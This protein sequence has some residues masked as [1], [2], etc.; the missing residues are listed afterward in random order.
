MN[1]NHIADLA[2]NAGITLSDDG[3]VIYIRHNYSFS[4]RSNWGVLWFLFGGLFFIM[5]PFIKHSGILSTYIGVTLGTLLV[6]LSIM[7][8]VRQMT[9]GL[10]IKDNILT[11]QYHLKRRSIILDDRITIK[12]NTKVMKV[13]RV[14]SMGSE[15]IVIT[16]L[17]EDQY[18]EIPVFSF[19]MDNIWADNAKQ[20]GNELTRII[21]AHIRQ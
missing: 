15:F 3:N 19:Q 8:L 12:M 11:I 21:K 18:K 10:Q 13:N 6:I 1:N 7:T 2:K 14:G 17:I 20:L 9:D 4:D 16:H 5:A